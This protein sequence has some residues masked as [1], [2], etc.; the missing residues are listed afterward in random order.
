MTLVGVGR[1]RI[2][3]TGA[4]SCAG[5]ALSGCA[6]TAM[7]SD[8]VTGTWQLLNAAEITPEST[9]LRLGVMRVECASGETGKVLEPQVRLEADRIVIRTP[10]EPLRLA[11][12]TC[13]SNTVVP[14][15][16]QLA[17]PVGERELFDAFCLDSTGRTTSFCADGGVR[18]R[19]Q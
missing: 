4:L 8:G 16:V 17:E 13:Q 7:P 11:E 5:L 18:W 15:T 3:L 10:V 2:M 14:V 19:W 6:S 12:G 1:W 9:T